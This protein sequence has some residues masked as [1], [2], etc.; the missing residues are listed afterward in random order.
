M[1]DLIFDKGGKNK[2]VYIFVNTQ[3]QRVKT[4]TEFT[5]V[6]PWSMCGKGWW[7]KMKFFYLRLFKSN[8]RFTE[9]LQKYHGESLY[10]LLLAC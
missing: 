8:F 5:V 1:I 9:E 4:Y 6:N 2:T 7:C 3:K 10:N